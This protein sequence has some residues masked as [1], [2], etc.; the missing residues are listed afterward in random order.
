MEV[1]GEYWVAV[2]ARTRVVI[3]APNSVRPLWPKLNDTEPTLFDAGK[4][5]GW[6]Q[7]AIPNFRTLDLLKSNLVVK[8]QD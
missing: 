2:A 4:H 6:S 7:P 5:R 8:R 3:R 1:D